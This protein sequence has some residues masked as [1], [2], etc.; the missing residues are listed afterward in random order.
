MLRWW[1]LATRAVR[2]GASMTA[3]HTA[4]HRFAGMGPS[5]GRASGSTVWAG[6]GTWR[7]TMKP[8]KGMLTSWSFSKKKRAS[9]RALG[10]GV[11]TRRKR[12]L[13]SRSIL[14]T[15]RDRAWNPSHRPRNS[16]KNWAISPMVPRPTS[17]LRTR[18]AASLPSS[19][20][21]QPLR[22]AGMAIQRMTAP[23]IRRAMRSG[24]V[25]KSSA[26]RVGGVST[27]TMS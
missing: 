4:A 10:A 12:V 7:F 2:L 5:G 9:V 8:P 6:S 16:S 13:G 20:A 18:A 14:W 26:F 11:V 15:S 3:S 21:R 22:V 23:S 27:T 24:A 17:R 25:R 1:L 19:S